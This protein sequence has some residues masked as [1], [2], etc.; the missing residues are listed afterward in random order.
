MIHQGDFIEQMR[1]QGLDVSGF[2]QKK[3]VA[4]VAAAANLEMKKRL[5]QEQQEMLERKR[6][7]DQQLQQESN[8][9]SNVSDVGKVVEKVVSYKSTK[10]VVPDVIPV[11]KK[12]GIKKGEIVEKLPEIPDKWDENNLSETELESIRIAKL[13]RQAN[14]QVV[15]AEPVIGPV[16][17]PVIERPV[18]EPVIEHPVIELVV[19][20]TVGT[21]PLVSEDDTVRGIKEDKEDKEDIE[22]KERI[23]RRMLHPEEDEEKSKENII[24]HK[25]MIKNTGLCQK[26]NKIKILIDTNRGRMCGDCKRRLGF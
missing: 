18:V 2:E 7:L 15:V 14:I 12:E 22:K 16:I 23:A 21:I 25:E 24:D 3:Q 6:R 11:E 19:D 1:L 10:D 26:C 5:E 9:S 8:V 20:D 4:A 17:E 13:A